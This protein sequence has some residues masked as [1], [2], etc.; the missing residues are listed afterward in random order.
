MKSEV[1]SDDVVIA[2]IG[3]Y[4]VGEHWDISLRTMGARAV[5]AAVRDSGNITPEGVFV[6][7]AFASI[8]THQTNLAAMIA[9]ESGL[10]VKISHEALDKLGSTVSYEYVLLMYAEILCS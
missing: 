4:P 7:N 2:G 9:D 3:L 8:L 1:L 6:G 10:A 5:R